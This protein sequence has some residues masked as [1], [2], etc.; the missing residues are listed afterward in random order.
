MIS[1]TKQPS[2]SIITHLLS[3][4]STAQIHNCYRN[5]SAGLAV[6]YLAKIHPPP[7][8]FVPSPGLFS[9]ET[10]K[11][12]VFFNFFFY[13]TFRTKQTQP[14][15]KNTVAFPLSL[16][17][18]CSDAPPPPPPPPRFHEVR[19]V[20]LYVETINTAPRV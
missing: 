20:A 12:N 18:I 11:V 15:L 9:L 3:S 16:V 5:C 13:F 8:F 6:A 14:F 7:L 17:V 4:T 2:A 19:D 1:P 10:L